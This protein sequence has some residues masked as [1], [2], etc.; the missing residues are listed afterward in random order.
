MLLSMDATKYYS[1]TTSLVSWPS[2]CQAGV[3]PS[4]LAVLSPDR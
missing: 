1:A 3:F 2:P 4:V